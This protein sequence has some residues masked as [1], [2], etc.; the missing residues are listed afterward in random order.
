MRVGLLAPVF[1]AALTAASAAHSQAA[2]AAS[3]DPVEQKLQAD[4]SAAVTS[5]DHA[6]QMTI[7]LQIAHREGLRGRFEAARAMLAQ[8]AAELRPEDTAPHAQYELELGRVIRTGGDPVAAT[9]H[10]EQALEIAKAGKHDALAVD[11]AHMLAIVATDPAQQI[12]R[13]RAAIALAEQSADPKARAWLGI[14][15]NNLGETFDDARRYGDA[16]GA[17]SKARAIC[18]ADACARVADWK[19]ARV[20][21]ELGDY[22]KAL[23]MLASLEQR[24]S[25]L[26]PRTQP[27][28]DEGD[29]IDYVYEEMGR[30][31]LA[32]ADAH[33]A[34]GA[35]ERAA[36]RAY[37]AKAYAEL[38][39]AQ[40]T[41]GA[42]APDLSDLPR[43]EALKNLA[44]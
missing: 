9:P 42:V 12:A 13:G 34:V 14:L 16:L 41:Q 1:I 5:G 22:A 24:W 4:R 32:L 43:L 44:Q 7:D 40:K 17:Y 15:W 11:A 3:A 33:P 35:K 10:F 25:K 26:G 18:T 30:V 23:S 39:A 27:A 19:L 2:P 21:R 38:A 8:V 36:A 6:A 37:F 31:H 28:F 29:G 20:H